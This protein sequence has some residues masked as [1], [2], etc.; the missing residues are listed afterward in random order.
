MWYVLVGATNI[1]IASKKQA[2]CPGGSLLTLAGNNLG[3]VQAWVP[4]APQMQMRGNGSVEVVFSTTNLPSE[5]RVL[6]SPMTSNSRLLLHFPRHRQWSPTPVRV[7]G[8][9]GTPVV[10]QGRPFVLI[11]GCQLGGVTCDVVDANGRN[12]CGQPR[13]VCAADAAQGNAQLLAMR[14]TP[15]CS[16]WPGAVG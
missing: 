6:M 13:Q 12:V 16:N 3:C 11:D 15:P 14:T 8:R 4:S 1:L 2:E 5:I 7:T 10:P 9:L